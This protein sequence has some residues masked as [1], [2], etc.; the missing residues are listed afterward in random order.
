MYFLSRLNARVDVCFF[1]CIFSRLNAYVN[2]ERESREVVAHGGEDALALQVAVVVEEE[3]HHQLRL[4]HQHLAEGRLGGR[5]GR[6]AVTRHAAVRRCDGEMWDQLLGTVYWEGG[7]A[8]RRAGTSLQ[9]ME[10]DLLV[11]ESV[12]NRGGRACSAWM[13]SL[14]WIPDELDDCKMRRRM[15]GK[16]TPISLLRCDLKNLIRMTK[17]SRESCEQG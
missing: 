12:H 5:V 17:M 6:S 11:S 8:R 1:E 3:V 9:R 13:V 16:K 7:R 4:A 2:G 14:F 10:G 15:L